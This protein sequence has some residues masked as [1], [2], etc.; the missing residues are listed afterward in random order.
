[1]NHPMKIGYNSFDSDCLSGSPTF[2]YAALQGGVDYMVCHFDSYLYRFEDAC[3]NAAAVAARIKELG[4]DFIANFEFQNFRL[5]TVGP[6]GYDWANRPDGSHRL[7]LDRRYIESLGSA[8]NLAGIEYDEFEHTVI[9]RNLSILLGAKKDV[10]VFAD[11]P[12]GGRDECSP[13]VAAH[14]RLKRLLAGYVS[15]LRASGAPALCGEHVFPVLFHLFAENGII[16]NFKSQKESYSN[17]QFSIAAGAALQYGTP[18][19]NC[20]DLWHKNTNPGHSPEEMYSNLV[21]AF[22][23]GIDR[24]YVE[25]VHAFFDSPAPGGSPDGGNAPVYNEYGRAFT[26]FATEY[27]GK[28][29]EWSFRDY[30]PKIGIIHMDDTFWGQGP[31][32]F[33]WKPMLYGDPAVRP[34]RRNAEYIRAIRL[35]SHKDSQKRSLG[36]D[37][38]WP[39]S[40]MKHRS[41]ASVN[42]LAVF[43]ENVTKERLECLELLFL[44]GDSIS[45]GTMN[46]VI[47]LVRDGGLTVVC[48][49]RFAPPEISNGVKGRYS[50]V[51]YGKGL[52]IV[53]DR[54]DSPRLKYRLTPFLGKK[55]E[56]TL[57]FAD[58]EFRMKIS[59]NGETF[60]VIE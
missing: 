28:E 52:F 3:R 33:M 26:R 41:F 15:E 2:D 55:G 9:N 7:R 14:D 19:Y 13:S 17:I 31:F 53:T 42:S 49:K 38:I 34:T 40:L 57:R 10:P 6:D 5:D 20:V 35:I 60:E 54:L 51:R 8:G 36:W 4:L 23:A 21:F 37:R 39:T 22:L 43:D 11:E 18:L 47:S 29:R 25:S 50:E 45:Q 16:P 27:R 24:V 58:R 56:M 30:R 12:C 32:K 44:T 48:P 59:P 46:A 1:M